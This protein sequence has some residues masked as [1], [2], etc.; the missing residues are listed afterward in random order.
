MHLRPAR[1]GFQ[2]QRT[3]LSGVYISLYKRTKS[4]INMQLYTEPNP[5]LGWSAEW[6]GREREAGEVNAPFGAR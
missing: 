1:G 4:S 5:S 2:K 6:F 3:L